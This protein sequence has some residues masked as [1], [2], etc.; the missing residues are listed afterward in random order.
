MKVAPLPEKPYEERYFVSYDGEQRE[1]CPI[2]IDNDQFTCKSWVKLKQCK[3]FFHQHC[4]DQWMEHK[5]TCPVC[6]QH[7]YGY[8][9]V[10]IEVISPQRR[11][12]QSASR[13]SVF[14]IVLIGVAF[15]VILIGVI[16]SR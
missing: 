9:Q 1:E 15:A 7:V 8:N 10:A 16:L 2:C 11:D 6:V 3:H 13:C 14:S 4:I 12:S 5:W